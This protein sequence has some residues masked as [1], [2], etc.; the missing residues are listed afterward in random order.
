MLRRRGY[1]YRGEARIPYMDCPALT[2]R[3]TDGLPRSPRHQSPIDPNPTAEATRQGDELSGV[4][5]QPTGGE[6]QESSLLQSELR[7][8]LFCRATL[9]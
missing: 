1:F 6:T 8:P 9:V 5:S 4:N 7:D 3:R 2:C